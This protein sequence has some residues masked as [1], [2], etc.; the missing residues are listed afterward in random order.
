MENILTTETKNNEMSLENEINKLEQ[1]NEEK[2]NQ[3]NLE[4]NESNQLLS[5]ENDSV[6]EEDSETSSDENSNSSEE[7]NSE[8]ESTQCQVCHQQTHKY[9]CPGCSIKFC[10]V[11]CSKKHKSET[12]CTGERSK[13]KFI[14]LKEFK[15]SDLSSG[16]NFYF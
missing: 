5:E 1:T 6:S 15:N 9:T 4:G 2:V 12:S 13:T 10:S 3:T 16:L 8:P 11:A 7:Q 14:D